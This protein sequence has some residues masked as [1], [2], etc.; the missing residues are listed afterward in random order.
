MKINLKSIEVKDCDSCVFNK[1]KASKMG[2]GS[3]HV[4]LLTKEIISDQDNYEAEEWKRK[5]KKFPK[6]CPFNKKEKVTL[7]IKRDLDGSGDYDSEI[8]FDLID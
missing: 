2:L 8:D 6:F 1:F 7:S 4:C 5:G 3:W